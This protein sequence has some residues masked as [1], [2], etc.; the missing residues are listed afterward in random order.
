MRSR[1]GDR[2]VISRSIQIRFWSFGRER[3]GRVFGS[4]SHGGIVAGLHLA[5]PCHSPVDSGCLPWRCWRRWPPRLWLA[6]RQMRHVAAH[7]GA[8]PPAFA[9]RVPLE[10]HQRAADYTIAKARFGLLATAFGS[11][12]AAGL[13]AARRARC[14]QRVGARGRAAALGRAG[15]RAGAAWRPSRSSARVLDLPF[16]WWRTFRIEQRFGFNRSTWRLFVADLL[17]SAAGRPPCSAC[18]WPRLVLWIMARTGGWWWLW[19]WAAWTAFNLLILVIYPTLHR[20]AVQQVR[21]AARRDAAAA[22]VQTLM[23]RCGF[24]GQGPVR[25]GRQHAVRRHGNA[26]FTGLGASQARGVLRH[27]CWPRSRRARWRRCWR[28]SSA[29]SSAATCSSAWWRCSR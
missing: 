10:A 4:G 22:R 20:A 13:D 18:R 26:Y 15:L 19:A 5:A 9:P 21:A 12:R 7:R 28:T 3:G 14:A 25:D 23:Q 29:T 16:E 24:R 2:P 11:A 8:V 6:T 17:K 27:A 1:S